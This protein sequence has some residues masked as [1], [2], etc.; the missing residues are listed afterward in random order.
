MESS[1]NNNSRRRPSLANFYYRF[2]SSSSSPR[3]LQHSKH[4]LFYCADH[5][6]ISASFNLF[7]PSTHC[8]ER[9]FLYAPMALCY[10]SYHLI[11]IAVCTIA[12]FRPE[13]E[14]EDWR[15]LKCFEG[16]HHVSLCVFVFRLL[17]GRQASLS[18]ARERSLIECFLICE[19][20]WHVSIRHHVIKSNLRHPHGFA[21]PFRPLMAWDANAHSLPS[22]CG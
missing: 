2:S 14:C 13:L 3:V 5:H 16:A 1:N 8:R 11:I 20:N 9:E 22:F 6:K 4:F 21:P 7:F 17:F 18:P 10:F 12:S 15:G 19:V